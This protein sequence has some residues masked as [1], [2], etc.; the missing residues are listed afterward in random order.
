M[1]NLFSESF[2][3]CQSALAL[4]TNFPLFATTLSLTPPLTIWAS[5]CIHSISTTPLFRRFSHSPRVPSIKT[6]SFGHKSF[7]FTGPKQW[8][9]LPHD[10]RHSQSVLK[11]YLFKSAYNLTP[12]GLNYLFSSACVCVCVCDRVHL[13]HVLLFVCE[14]CKARCAHPAWVRCR[15]IKKSHYY[16]NNIYQAVI[17]RSIEIY[18]L[19][20][21]LFAE[22]VVLIMIEC[23]F[24]YASVQ[25]TTG[26]CNYW[27]HYIPLFYIYIYGFF[28]AVYH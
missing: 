22:S 10:V 15:A 16:D 6:K 9:S 21:L 26:Y 14:A 28:K 17:D 11:T 13:C 7:S 1:Y 24:M 12:T 8:N 4:N 20:Q 27:L 2:T 18:K 19:N 25:V 5:R 3:G 23:L